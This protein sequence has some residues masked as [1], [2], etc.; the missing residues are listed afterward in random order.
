MVYIKFD[1]YQ[2]RG[3]YHWQQIANNIF[4]FN[5]Y[6]SARYQQVLKVIPKDKSLKILDIGCGDGVLSWKL[7][8]QTKS[9]ITGVDTDE[10]SLKF[11]RKE[12]QKRN[13][14]ANF[15]KANAHKLP[16][17]NNSFDVIIATE[18]IEHLE[19]PQIMLREIKRVLK[20]K[21]QVII[22]TPIKLSETPQDKM[23]VK[24]YTSLELK[25][26]LNKY[27]DKV[28]IK[29]SHPV[30]LKNLYTFTLVKIGKYHLDLFRW[31][32]NLIVLIIKINP[33][34]LKLGKSSQQIAICQNK[35]VLK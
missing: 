11:A 22:T 35:K 7:F 15:I 14:R 25:N 19:K 28:T 34:N 17:K 27:F 12:I 26:L 5:A 30:W 10:H 2:K 6:V 29:T 4:T 20:P 18:I 33:F 21:G 8:N 1:K 13:A 16:F 3:A 24:E 23:H 9:K 31:L 32:I